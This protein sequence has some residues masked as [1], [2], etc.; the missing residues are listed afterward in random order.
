MTT[1]TLAELIQKQNNRCH[2]CA[3]LMT[4]EQKSPHHATL[5]HLQDKWASPGNRKIESASNLVAACFQCNN[6]RGNA[7]NVIA[8]NYYR[9]QANKRQMKLAVASTPSQV[10]YSLFGPVPSSLFEI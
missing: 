1:V 4:R 2:Y 8:R 10:L 5:E 9:K 7:R 6:S 3:C